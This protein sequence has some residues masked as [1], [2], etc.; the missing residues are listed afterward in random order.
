MGVER[1]TGIWPDQAEPLARTF[2][3]ESVYA[4]A[5]KQIESLHVSG[6]LSK[7][8]YDVLL[9]TTNP[10][11]LITNV[12]NSSRLQ[13]GG[14]YFQKVVDST[15]AR[16]NRYAD[17]IDMIAQSSPQAYGLNIV[18]LVWGSLK[19]LLVVAKDVS[20][21]HDTIVQ[22]L[23]YVRQSLPNLGALTYI[24]GESQLQLLYKPLLDIYAAVISFGLQ[25]AEHLS[26]TTSSLKALAHSAWSSLQADFE[27]SLTKLKAAGQIVEQAANV[28]HMYATD[29][30]R[31]DQGREIF[32]QE[33]FRR[34]M[35]SILQTNAICR[36]TYNYIRWQE[37]IHFL[38]SKP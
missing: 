12:S 14:G 28:E 18:G 1:G 8:Y 6:R 32:R 37:R 24:Y 38:L 9:R 3:L 31:K 17:A 5:S 26:R 21:A 33:L 2:S 22:T 20:A 4:D 15:V 29:S 23:D 19:F 36:S 7:E 34:G 16:I 11:D 25:T 10:D 30:I 35:Y 13:D 27:L